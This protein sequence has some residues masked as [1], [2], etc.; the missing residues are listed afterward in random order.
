MLTADHFE[1][2]TGTNALNKVAFA[3][4]QVLLDERKEV[5]GER[6]L[7]ALA[8]VAELMQRPTDDSRAVDRGPLQNRLGVVP[9]LTQSS[10]N[11]TEVHIVRR[12]SVMDHIA[13]R[14][15]GGAP[16]PSQFPSPFGPIADAFP[17]TADGMLR[18]VA[19]RPHASE[20]APR[21]GGTLIDVE[22]SNDKSD[23]STLVVKAFPSNAEFLLAHA[24]A[25]GGRG[26]VR[27]FTES[28]RL[29]GLEPGVAHNIL[30][31][32]ETAAGDSKMDLRYPTRRVQGA[33]LALQTGGRGVKRPPRRTPVSRFPRNP[34]S[35][36]VL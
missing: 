8:E 5:Q 6:N 2:V 20:A 11:N 31:G 1:N 23:P 28:V 26:S 10:R 21:N 27:R 32:S 7:D 30:I 35:G 9:T 12:R 19:R 15:T 18:V 14:S 13:E 34:L 33:P 24:P 4:T 17:G 16:R 36:I 22:V 3:N 29:E 25:G